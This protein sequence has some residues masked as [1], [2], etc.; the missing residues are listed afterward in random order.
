MREAEYYRNRFEGRIPFDE[1]IVIVKC[2]TCKTEAEF[3]ARAEADA[4]KCECNEDKG[5]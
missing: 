3:F 2:Y 4:W 5:E 1:P